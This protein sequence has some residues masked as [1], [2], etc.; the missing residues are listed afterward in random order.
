MLAVLSKFGPQT[1]SV[2]FGL[3]LSNDDPWNSDKAGE[4]T[5]SCAEKFLA[6]DSERKGQACAGE[7]EIPGKV[8]F[9]F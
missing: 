1:F 8:F 5:E 2:A 7:E 6:P 9:H 4:E 3:L